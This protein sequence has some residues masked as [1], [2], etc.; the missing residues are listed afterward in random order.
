MNFVDFI[1]TWFAPWLFY[2]TLVVWGF[3]AVFSSVFSKVD[4]H[5]KLALLLSGVSV[6]LVC[7]DR[8]LDLY[9]D[10]QV[11]QETIKEPF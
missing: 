8:L 10:P 7:G 4:K 9:Q 6:I 3:V 11:E 1:F 5:T 2:V